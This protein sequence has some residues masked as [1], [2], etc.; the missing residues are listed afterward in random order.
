MNPPNWREWLYS[1]KALLAAMLAL[2]IA[3]ALQLPNPYWAMG[4]VYIVSHPLSGATSSK[5]AF[6][7]FG[8]VV[9]ASAAIAIVPWL[10]STP[11]L[12][13]CVIAAWTGVL[14][15]LALL[16]RTPTTYALLLSAY[17]MP[18]VA[19]PSMMRPDTVFD[20]GLA[21][22]E[23]ILIGI[24]C[25]AVINTTILPNRIAPVMSAQIGRV[26]NDAAHWAKALLDVRSRDESAAIR[27]HRLL[28]DI[29][30]LD[31]LIVHL[32][33]D[34][35]S[36]EQARQARL[37]R[38]RLTMLIPQLSGLLDPLL[39]VDARHDPVQLPVVALVA[40]VV[41]WMQPDAGHD[42]HRAS[43]LAAVDTCIENTGNVE[44]LHDV[45]ARTVLAR[46]TELINLWDDCLR[47][48][49]SF[50]Q[51][52]PTRGVA[53]HFGIP[54]ALGR[55][56]HID[57]GLLVFKAASVASC[58]AVASWIWLNLGW[59]AGAGGV[60]SVAVAYCFF[61]ALDDPVP[62]IRS[63]FDWLL[64]G[65]VVAFVYLYAILPGVHTF[66][67]LA[68]VLAPPLLIVGTVTGRP[69]YTGLVMLFMV[70]SIAELGIRDA[71]SGD[72]ITFSN[73]TL[74][75]LLGC[76]F[77]VVWAS[78]STPFGVRYVA[79]R[80]A[81]ANWRDLARMGSSADTRNDDRIL[82]RMIDRSAQL[83][84]RMVVMGS[85]NTLQLDTIR[86]VRV[87][88]RLGGLRRSA[89]MLA[90]AERQGVIRVIRETGRYYGQCTEAGKLLATPA[91]LIAHLDA[92]IVAL[93]G[94]ADP[95]DR[96]ANVDLAGLRFAL[97][98]AVDGDHGHAAP[99]LPLDPTGLTA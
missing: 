93:L 11:V 55:T 49:A 94:S 54:A 98:T 31:A 52:T 47:L 68:A 41:A 46:L 72:F 95:C 42:D 74:G 36:Q 86:D 57:H 43:L 44:T 83:L 16:I 66:V 85:A 18:L 84:P 5:A 75:S 76:A 78:A 92:L 20:I 35:V 87:C 12:L 51:A 58:V 2:Y 21:R 62:Q 8:T 56:Q 89:A 22:T 90:P 9:G 17:T 30:A 59:E 67:G 45:W 97:L 3:L 88:L 73:N 65:T 61:A 27:G 7:V 81:R 13:G 69:Q 71:Y 6:R 32:S 99:P 19:F 37:L 4:S 26:L 34:T 29:T 23:E 91:T 28:V 25:A 82:A 53:T 40:R 50:R 15:Y 96:T 79:Y 14:L 39:A 1:A 10:A 48:Q 60:V 80:L 24:V 77:A 70:Q 64:V 63:F 38:L 33:F